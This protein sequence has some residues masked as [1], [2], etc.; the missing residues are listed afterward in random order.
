MKM[1]ADRENAPSVLGMDAKS[2]LGGGNGARIGIL[3]LH[4]GFN[5]G[6]MLQAFCLASSLQARF[7]AAR[8]EVVDYRHPL[9]TSVYGSADDERKL[10]LARFANERLPLSPGAFREADAGMVHRYVRERYDL[11]VVGSDEVWRLTYTRRFGWLWVEQSSPWDPPFPNAYWPG[12]DAGVPRVAY[13]VSAGATNWRLIPRTHRTK[14][15]AILSGFSLLGVRDQRTKAFLEWIDPEIGAKAEWVPDPTFSWDWLSC[16][17]RDAL[18]EKLDRLGVDFG[19]PRLGVVL[20]DSPWLERIVAWFRDKG[21]QIV[22]FSISNRYSDVQLF[23]QGLTPI[24]WAAAFGLMDA[25]LSQRMHACIA[26]I[27]TGTPFAALD[28]YGNRV[29]DESKLKD[30]MRSFD[31]LDFYYAERTNSF[32]R[33]AET[34]ER[35]AT[36]PWPVERVREIRESFRLRSEAFRDRMGGVCRVG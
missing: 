26:C 27:H 10:A 24:E 36:A 25:C 2:K 11:L 5:E 28:F 29:D 31:L 35:M 21:F 23:R 7:P 6:A 33:L 13:A 17:D 8:V 18:R 32:A 22:G 3:T 14:M 30:L 16:V 20:M 19:R 4:S 1:I 12:E 15:R 9:K 34:C